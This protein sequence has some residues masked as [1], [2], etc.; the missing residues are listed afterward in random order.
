MRIKNEKKG[1]KDG[2]FLSVTVFL[3]A[4]TLVIALIPTEAEAAIYT[5]TVRLHIRA[6][7][8]SE[9]DQRVKLEIRDKVLDNFSVNPTPCNKN[10]AVSLI[11]AS[12]EDIRLSVDGWLSE[13]GCDYG[14]EVRLTEEWF[15]TRD[16]GE[17]SLPAGKYT[18]LVIELGG[19]EGENWWCVMFPPM[20]REVATGAAVSYTKE[21]SALV[22]G[23]K[24]AVKFKLLE[25]VAELS[26]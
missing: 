5:D 11:S 14:C 20:C 15:E 2:A 8:D 3:L 18:S 23:G 12:V 10:E 6:R 22:Y 4:M 16:Y 13:L 26:R 17:F 7:S 25:L 1:F 21:E 24:Y 9:E 19:G